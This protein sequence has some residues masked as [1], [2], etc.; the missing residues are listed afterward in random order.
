MVIVSRDIDHVLV[1]CLAQQLSLLLT[2][3]KLPRVFY[4]KGLSR[5][6]PLAM[7]FP[8]GCGSAGDAGRSLHHLID[9]ETL[10][11]VVSFNLDVPTPIGGNDGGIKS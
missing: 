8:A 9:D 1:G 3:W 11:P 10:S 4:D 2:L 7:G 5:I 6:V